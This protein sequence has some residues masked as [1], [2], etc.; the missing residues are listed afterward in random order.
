M[1]PKIAWINLTYKCNLRCSWCYGA[2][3]WGKTETMTF[4]Q[5]KEI[6]SIL[7]SL[8][9]EKI[10]LLGGEPTLHP[11]IIEIVSECR[12]RNIRVSIVSNGLS[13]AHTDFCESIISAGKEFL[14]VSLSM[15][16]LPTESTS[17]PESKAF[18]KFE[19][20]FNNLRQYDIEPN[21]TI[22]ISS[23]F[24]NHI[25]DVI[26]WIAVN[27]VKSVDF[28]VGVPSISQGEVNGN[29]TITPQDVGHIT[30]KLFKTGQI[31]GIKTSF[32]NIPLCALER[33]TAEEFRQYDVVRNG[34]GVQNKRNILFNV[35]GDLITCNH[36]EGNILSELGQLEDSLNKNAFEY[37]WNSED[38][39]IKRNMF[40][41]FPPS[42][43]KNCDMLDSCR[44]GG[45]PITWS[46]YNPH[47]YINGWNNI[48][49][50]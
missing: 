16:T 20:G 5:V 43:C 50:G 25:S 15:E 12:K 18:R 2:D 27:E 34:C 40:P 35:H 21:L 36:L 24:V 4:I 39:Q 3:T 19:Q 47:N 41:E 23:E 33:E 42:E 7:K 9:C 11:D 37:F 6:L 48:E 45:C 30:T 32:K 31:L 28:V 13:F 22:I 10:I 17:V 1:L 49:K 44:G 38:M 29:Y 46:Y 8:E 14:T 26:H